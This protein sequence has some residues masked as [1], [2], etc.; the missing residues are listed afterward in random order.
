MNV[1]LIVLGSLHVSG[2]GIYPRVNPNTW[3]VW[4]PSTN[5]E[6]EFKSWPDPKNVPE[7]IRLWCKAFIPDIVSNQTV[8]NNTVMPILLP[9]GFAPPGYGGVCAVIDGRSWSEEPYQ[10]PRPWDSRF[11]AWLSVG[12]NSATG[13]SKVEANATCG[14]SH[15]V[16][17]ASKGCGNGVK[18]GDFTCG[19]LHC[20]DEDMQIRRLRCWTAKG[21]WSKDG[22][23]CENAMDVVAT[24]VY[25]YGRGGDPCVHPLGV[26]SPPA[27]WDIGAVIFPTKRRVLLT[28]FVDD[29]PSTECY[30][31]ARDKGEW[32]AVMEL[33]RLAPKPG[34]LAIDLIGFSDRP[35]NPKNVYVELPNP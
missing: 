19:P 35:V 31:Q 30:A 28:G 16:C 22:E 10:G 34:D 32:G 29:A 21:G 11:A 5:F 14:F 15:N 23:D 8:G 6:A 18:Y 12:K 7:E 33:T 27:T 24:K 26:P 9:G 20:P 13:T 4:T 17:C 25:F 1:L 2:G 3:P